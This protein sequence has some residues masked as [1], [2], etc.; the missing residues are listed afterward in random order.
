MFAA[1]ARVVQITERR[2][3]DR[4]PLQS[5]PRTMCVSLPFLRCLAEEVAPLVPHMPEDSDAL[6]G[7]GRDPG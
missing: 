6:P 3:V 1:T 5:R 7:R 2:V 4:R